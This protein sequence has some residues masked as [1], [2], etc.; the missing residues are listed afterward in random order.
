[1]MNWMKDALIKFFG[2]AVQGRTYLNMLYLLL[3]FPLGLSYFVILVTGLA[4]GIRSF[5][6]E[7]C[8]S[9]I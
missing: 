3:S 5:S 7:R 1:M 8:F 9:G 2:V 6:A 4:L